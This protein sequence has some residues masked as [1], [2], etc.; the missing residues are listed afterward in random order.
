[1]RKLPDS[2]TS[3]IFDGVKVK[4]GIIEKG[5][6]ESKVLDKAL[7][8]MDLT[9]DNVLHL[10]RPN[11]PIYRTIQDY[12]FKV[13]N[14]SLP[15]MAKTGCRLY[16]FRLD[17]LHFMDK[18]E[19]DYYLTVDGKKSFFAISESLWDVGGHADPNNTCIFVTEVNQSRNIPRSDGL[20]FYHRDSFYCDENF[21]VGV[22]TESTGTCTYNGVQVKVGKADEKWVS[23]NIKN[24]KRV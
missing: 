7:S 8:D 12:Q 20:Y 9:R 15:F 17:K 10:P 13:K 4:A 23:D 14:V 5:S 16:T 21:F 3:C 24:V 1:M 18:Y 11:I 2:G 6:V 19:S 22:K